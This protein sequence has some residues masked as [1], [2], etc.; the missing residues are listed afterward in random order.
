VG[1]PFTSDQFFGVFAAYNRAFW[2][3]AVVLWIVNVAALALAAA[4]PAGRSRSLTYFLGLLWLWNAVT[5]HAML[6]TRINPAAWLFSALFAVQAVLFFWTGLRRRVDYFSSTVPLRWLGTGLAGYALT[7][8]ILNLILGHEYPA[9]PTF[10]VPC[11][12]A[13]LTIGVL[14]TARG[15]VPLAL[16]VIPAL[17]GFVGGSAAVL[18]SVPADY[19]LL[20]AGVLLTIVLVTARRPGYAGT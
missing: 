2:F 5:Y 13:I 6:F 11:P 12:T 9:T 8:P 7:Y 20:G 19:V 15:G 18:L 1:L 3:V 16:A 4:N 17:W 14:L 10:G